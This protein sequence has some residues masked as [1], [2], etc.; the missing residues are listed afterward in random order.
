MGLLQCLGQFQAFSEQSL[1][2]DLQ[3]QKG[4]FPLQPWMDFSKDCKRELAIFAEQ[5]LI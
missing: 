1:L 4:L 2:K 5:L 3:K